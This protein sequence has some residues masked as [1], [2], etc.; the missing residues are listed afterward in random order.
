MSP[1]SHTHIHTP[2]GLR[3]CPG[4]PPLPPLLLSSSPLAPPPPPPPPPPPRT[5]NQPLSVRHVD[6]ELL[7]GRKLEDERKQGDSERD[8]GEPEHR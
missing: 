4:S 3:P 7:R 5:G 6:P 1:D 2:A 8:D